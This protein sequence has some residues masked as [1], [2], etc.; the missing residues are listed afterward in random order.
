MVTSQVS[1]FARNN[2]NGK[3][4]FWLSKI[5]CGRRILPRL[6]ILHLPFWFSLWPSYA[7][8]K[9][10]VETYET[11]SKWI[12]FS[13][14]ANILQCCPPSVILFLN[15]IFTFPVSHEI[16]VYYIV[17]T[18]FE[19]YLSKKRQ[20]KHTQEKKSLYLRFHDENTMYW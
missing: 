16:K 7:L 4:C 19:I 11:S 13:N 10:F 12:L 8:L 20:T 18:K 6:E 15:L 5:T 3:A 2:C 14:I 9:T 1:Y 17:I